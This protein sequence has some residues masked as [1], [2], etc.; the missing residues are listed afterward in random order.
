MWRI[1]VLTT[2]VTVSPASPFTERKGL[3]NW[4]YS[5]WDCR[6]CNCISNVVNYVSVIPLITTCE[7]YVSRTMTQCYIMLRNSY[8]YRHLK[9]IV[10]LL[11]P[12]EKCGVWIRIPSRVRL[13]DQTLPFREGAGWR[14]YLSYISQC[15]HCGN[16]RRLHKCSLYLDHI[17][18]GSHMSPVELFVTA[19]K[20]R[21][22]WKSS[23]IAWFYG[24]SK[25]KT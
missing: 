10:T 3:V 24:I 12:H 11:S 7:H 6:Q 14:D 23:L 16:H 8:C 5:T 17:T 2:S 1:V 22:Q 19:I 21:D 13:V 20:N 9:Y 18:R 4:P 25:D 15:L